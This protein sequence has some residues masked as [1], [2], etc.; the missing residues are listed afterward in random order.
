MNQN[1]NRKRILKELRQDA[2]PVLYRRFEK[3]EHAEQF[4]SGEIRFRNLLYY[5]TLEDKTRRDELEGISFLDTK[6]LPFRMSDESGGEVASGHL[7]EHLKISI[8]DPE[9]YFIS[10]FST[11][12]DEKHRI[13]GKWVVRIDNPS[14]LFHDLASETPN[15]FGLLWGPVIYDDVPKQTDVLE[16]RDTWRRK[17]ASFSHENE[18]RIALW[19][20]SK[21]YC[22]EKE[23]Y[24]FDYQPKATELSLFED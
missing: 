18:F 13:W 5:R 14:K 6:G 20:S 4:I 17:R 2:P 15:G 24:R 16:N 10:S 1:E 21:T 19:V 8:V 3:K 7:T 23:V 9:K 12:I 22:P 11:E